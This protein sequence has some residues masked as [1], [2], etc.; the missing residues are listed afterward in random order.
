M[1]HDDEKRRNGVVRDGESVRV[2]MML[3][4]NARYIPPA[5]GRVTLADVAAMGTV[6]A[7]TPKLYAAEIQPIA[8]ALRTISKRETA[9][10]I[11][12]MIEVTH[13]RIKTRLEGEIQMAQSGMYGPNGVGETEERHRGARDVLAWLEAVHQTLQGATQGL[14]DQMMRDQVDYAQGRKAGAAALYAERMANAWK[15]TR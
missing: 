7:T 1:R 5:P 6:P 11:M 10:Q 4:D 15:H 8:E 13:T 3:A 14:R 9:T 2:P 12:H